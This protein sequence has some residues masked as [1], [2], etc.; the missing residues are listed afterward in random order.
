M[1]LCRSTGLSLFFIG[2]IIRYSFSPPI[3]VKNFLN[4]LFSIGFLSIPIVSMTCFFSGAVLAL[5]TYSGFSNFASESGIAAIVV[6]SIT[7]ELSPVMAALMVSARSGAAIAAEIGAMRVS[8]Q[9]DALLTL[10]IY[11]VR[12]LLIPR[13]FAA[14]VSLPLLVI[15]GDIVGVFGGYVVRVYKLGFNEA[16][17]IANTFNSLAFT[18]IRLG[19]V[20]ATVFGCVFSLVSCYFGYFSERGAIG[21]GKA[22]TNSVV[23]SA[24]L[25]LIANYLVTEIMF[26]V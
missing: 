24:V 26:G 11:P 21:V 25:I 1:G 20:K 14:I 5:Q 9:I 3:Y 16:N 19:L 8:E 22:T 23:I 17:Y 4:Q 18:D 6:L 2:T 12:F 13:T 10:S 15:L 7:R